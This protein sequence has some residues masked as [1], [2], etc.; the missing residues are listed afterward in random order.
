MSYYLTNPTIPLLEASLKDKS[1]PKDVYFLVG[2]QKRGMIPWRTVVR[3]RI[4]SW[5]I[6]LHTS[7]SIFSLSTVTSLH[8]KTQGQGDC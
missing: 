4:T 6:H 1:F 8:R 5:A 2:R 3:G 7:G